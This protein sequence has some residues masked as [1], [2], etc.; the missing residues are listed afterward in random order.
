MV[1]TPQHVLSCKRC[2]ASDCVQS[3][4]PCYMIE[5]TTG[6]PKYEH[7]TGWYKRTTPVHTSY[8]GGSGD[9]ALCKSCVRFLCTKLLVLRLG[10]CTFFGVPSTIVLLIGLHNQHF[11]NSG[12][13]SLLPFFGC[14]LSIGV[15]IGGAWTLL[16]IVSLILTATHLLFGVITGHYKQIGALA[17]AL[18]QYGTWRYYRNCMHPM[19]NSLHN[20][21]W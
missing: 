9:I 14:I 6:P 10:M 4:T 7:H 2:S 17:A 1:T 11:T 21:W 15:F 8:Y 5:E 16:S 18:W 13:D 19:S 12:R 20:K 3:Y